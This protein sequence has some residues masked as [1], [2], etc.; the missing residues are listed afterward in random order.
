MSNL[1]VTLAKALEQAGI[2]Y[3]IIGGQAV[4]IYGEPRLTRDVDITL[5][6]TPD[7]LERLLR[8][9]EQL[10]LRVLVDDPHT[11]A[12]QTWVLPTLDEASGLRVDY[13]FSWTPYEQEALARARPVLIEG[14]PVRF[15]APEDVVIHKILAGRP[16]DL[17]DVRTILRKQPLDI[18]LIRRWLSA[19]SETID[20]DIIGSFDQ[21]YKEVRDEI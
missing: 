4:L 15:A 18:A 13:I 20:H 9:V 16:R 12:Q 10:H 2:P 8:V 5:G 21:L 7:E 19:L 1:L 14:Y 6:I 3:M 17:E 11:F